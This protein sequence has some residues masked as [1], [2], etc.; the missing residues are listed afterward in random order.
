[1]ISSSSENEAGLGEAALSLL[2][3]IE[4]DRMLELSLRGG[5]KVSEYLVEYLEEDV[6]DRFGL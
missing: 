3:K 4:P 1:L 5:G 2:G 6:G